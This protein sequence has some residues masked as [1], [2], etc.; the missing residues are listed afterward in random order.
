MLLHSLRS[1]ISTCGTEV[2]QVEVYSSFMVQLKQEKTVKKKKLTEKQLVLM[3]E[4]MERNSS[5]L[6]THDQVMCKNG[7]MP[8]SI[9]SQ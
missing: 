3:A 8:D 4:H 6:E 2:E 7:G 5:W 9:T 1:N